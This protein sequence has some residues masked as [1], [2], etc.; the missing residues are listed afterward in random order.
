MRKPS[1]VFSLRRL[2][3]AAATA[4]GVV[5]TR[6]AEGMS[7]GA[8]KVQEKTPAVKKGAKRAVKRV[9]KATARKKLKKVGKKR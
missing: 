9:A 4:A 2:S 3:A 5:L 7:S 6:A 8:K 1:V